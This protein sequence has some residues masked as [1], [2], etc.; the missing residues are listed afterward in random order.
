MDRLRVN[1][2]IELL[3]KHLCVDLGSA[4]DKMIKA[5]ANDLYPMIQRCLYSLPD[6]FA[7]HAVSLHFQKS[8]AVPSPSKSE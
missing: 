2:T 5:L 4:S 3:L 8:L 1:C 7:N 6:T